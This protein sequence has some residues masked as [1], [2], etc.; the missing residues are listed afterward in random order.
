MTRPKPPIPLSSFTKPEWSLP[1]GEVAHRLKVDPA[2][3]TCWVSLCGLTAQA[4][5]GAGWER[6]WGR[7]AKERQRCGECEAAARDEEQSDE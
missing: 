4:G 7:A 2:G 5:S 6:L 3:Y 1:G